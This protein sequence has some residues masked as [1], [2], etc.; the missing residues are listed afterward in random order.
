MKAAT[1]TGCHNGAMVSA[2]RLLILPVLCA[3]ACADEPRVGIVD[4]QEAFQRSPLAMVAVHEIKAQ[5]GSGDRDLKKRGRA[6]A[7]LRQ[8][9]E[10]GGVELDEEQR[11]QVEAR[12]AEE[13]ALLHERQRAYRAD[14]AAA[15][16]RQ[17][18]EL[19]ARVEEVAREVARREGLALLL[20][21]E[22]L[23]YAAS[24]E[25]IARVD[26]TEQVARALLEKINPT[27]IPDAVAP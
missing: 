27:E 10:H 16:E 14:L 24:E 3:A 13:T 20:R 7:E 25:D 26:I 23:L 11:A 2:T 19:I 17:G 8:R 15:R 9:L 18:E 22:G 21:R 5:L 4:V 6:L 12:I 1:A